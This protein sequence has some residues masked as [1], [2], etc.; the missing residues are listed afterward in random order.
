[1]I[2][3]AKKN[4]VSLLLI[5]FVCFLSTTSVFANTSFQLE[6]IDV[7]KVNSELAKN[8]TVNFKKIS[9]S[10]VIY[11]YSIDGKTFKNVDKILSNN[12]IYTSVFE[13]TKDGDSFLHSFESI[14]ENSSITTFSDSGEKLNSIYVEKTTSGYNWKY[15]SSYN[16]DTS[17]RNMTITAIA[18]A[19][20]AAISGPVGVFMAVAGYIY[21]KKVE[22][23]YYHVNLYK[24]LNSSPHRPAFKRVTYFYT[25][26]SHSHAIP[27]NPVVFITKP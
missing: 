9:N 5:L 21:D 16:G 17:F 14:I 18:I 20:G 12:K 24:D 1:M 25:D 15:Q 7:S 23:V 3:L 27:G 22:T 11:T 13:V 4:I 8:T 6:N 2:T 10:E 26:K 19:L